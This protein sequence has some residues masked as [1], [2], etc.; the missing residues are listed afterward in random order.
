MNYDHDTTEKLKKNKFFKDKVLFF[1]HRI[2][3]DTFGPLSPFSDEDLFL[4]V[5]VDSFAHFVV[6]IQYHISML[7]MHIKHFK[8]TDYQN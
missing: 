3:F 7:I 1:N 8:I 5:K 2:T 4:I 6:L